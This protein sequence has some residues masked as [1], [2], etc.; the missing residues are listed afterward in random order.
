MDQSLFRQTIVQF[1]VRELLKKARPQEE[2]RFIFNNGIT[3]LTS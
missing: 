3:Q 2:A 1:V